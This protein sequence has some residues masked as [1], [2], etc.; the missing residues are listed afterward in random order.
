MWQI[1]TN[2]KRVEL[3]TIT[4]VVILS[5]STLKTIE[6]QRFSNRFLKK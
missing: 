6:I 1:K 4:S 2:S 3:N 5:K